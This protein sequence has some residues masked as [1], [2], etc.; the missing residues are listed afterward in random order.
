MALASS[1]CRE[2]N[3][4][5]KQSMGWDMRNFRIIAIMGHPLKAQAVEFSAGLVTGIL[6]RGYC[7]VTVGLWRSQFVISQG[8]AHR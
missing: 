1:A 2:Q 8:M 6:S 4:E 7:W 3:H 5:A